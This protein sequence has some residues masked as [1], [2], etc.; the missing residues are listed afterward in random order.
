MSTRLRERV[1]C[2]F[3]GTCRLRGIRNYFS[4][5]DFKHHR[6]TKHQLQSEHA[7]LHFTK[8]GNGERTL[9]AF[10]GFGQTGEAFHA[11]ADALSDRYTVYLFDIFFHGKSEWRLNEHPIEKKTWKLLME[12]FLTGHSISN[13]SV[14]GFS[15]GGKFALA[16][17][18]AFPEHA[19]E[20]FLLAPDGIKTSLWYSLATY[21]IMLRKL[22][23]SMITH[24][25]RFTS[26]ARFAH[27]AGL[28]DKGILRFVESQMNTEE[29]RRRV[30]YSWVVFR[31]LKF[32]M[33]AIANTINRYAIRLVLVAGKFDKVITIQN[34][35]LLLDKVKVYELAT[36]DTGHNGVIEASIPALTGSTYSSA[37]K[38]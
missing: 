6:V 34:M 30:Y 32:D 35:K 5:L 25:N 16:T 24:P 18:E 11:L 4:F 19:K 7:T 31:H 27:R 23:K 10:H 21:P 14:L 29:K 28:I 2:F 9:I 26:I 20:I 38:I 12:S 1:W 17:L 22:F 13:F 3:Y 37:G 33:T 15:M 36:P 8:T